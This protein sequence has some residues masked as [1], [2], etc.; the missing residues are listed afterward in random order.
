LSSGAGSGNGRPS[1]SPG[2]L[3][4]REP[5]LC[6]SQ[7]SCQLVAAALQS[8]LLLPQPSLRLNGLRAGGGQTLLAGSE[9]AE[10]LTCVSVSQSQGGRQL[11]NA[12]LGRLQRISTAHS[13]LRPLRQRG[14]AAR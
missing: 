6:I 10:R 8:C 12:A 13:L 14:K 1:C 7:L 9:T 5:C 2:Q 11:R 3:R 4:S